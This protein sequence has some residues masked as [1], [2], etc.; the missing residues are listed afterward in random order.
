MWFFEKKIVISAPN[1][2]NNIGIKIIISENNF[3][4]NS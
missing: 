2:N 1:N 4:L 3:F